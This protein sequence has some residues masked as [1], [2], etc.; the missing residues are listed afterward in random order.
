[1]SYCLTS[2]GKRGK[3]VWSNVSEFSRKYFCFSG[4]NFC[5]C[6]KS[7]CFQIWE[8]GKH[9]SNHW[10]SRIF[11]RQC[12]LRLAKYIYIFSVLFDTGGFLPHT[13]S[14]WIRM[15]ISRIKRCNG[16][17]KQY[18]IG[19]NWSDLAYEQ[20]KCTRR[21]FKQYLICVYYLFVN[22]IQGLISTPWFYFVVF[23]G[24]IGENP[25]GKSIFPVC[26]CAV[27][28]WLTSACVFATKTMAVRIFRSGKISN[29]G[30]IFFPIVHLFRLG[31]NGFW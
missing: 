21:C 28:V 3:S 16:I 17:L 5:F 8:T 14:H 30:G 23:T 4:S 6:N 19:M 13:N 29:F 11:P 2:V 18:P 1:M 7:Q 10:K 31:S 22:I 15:L 24:E 12:L 26:A 27:Q 20:A 25:Q 9:L